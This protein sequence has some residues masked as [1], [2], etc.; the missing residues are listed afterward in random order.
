MRNGRSV[1]F[2]C[3]QQRPLWPLHC[4]ILTVSATLTI[5]GPS[6]AASDS[7]EPQVPIAPTAH[8]QSAHHVLTLALVL[9]LPSGFGA[10]IS[11]EPTARLIV[12]G[13]LA[14]WLLVSE[15]SIYT[16][17]VLFRRSDDDLTAGIRLHRVTSLLSSDDENA[18]QWLVSMEGGYE[19]T[20]RSIVLAVD[21][22]NAFLRRGAFCLCAAVTGEFRIGYRW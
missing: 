19:H 10:D 1:R 6:M 16:R 15:A 11:V 9:R 7:E 3:R 12:G 17:A 2:I 13:Q 14:S 22:A 21:V 5:T 8:E 20:I 4:Q 18:S